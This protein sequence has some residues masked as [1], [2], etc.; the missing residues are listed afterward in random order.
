[1][2]PNAAVAIECDLLRSYLLTD[3]KEVLGTALCNICHF[4]HTYH[5]RIWLLIVVTNF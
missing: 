3:E 5:R 4:K 2:P 1:M